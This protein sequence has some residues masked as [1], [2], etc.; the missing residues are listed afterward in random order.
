[1]FDED[2]PQGRS[3]EQLRGIEGGKVKAIYRCLATNAGL[4]WEGRSHETVLS[5]PLNRAIS[6]ANAALYGITEAVILTLG[7]SPS[8][9][10]VHRGD[11]RSFV[12]DVADCLKFKTVVPLAMRVAKESSEDIEGRIRRGCRDEFFSCGI[13]NQLVTIVNGVIEDGLAASD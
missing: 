4:K 2:A 8:I 12:F 7:Y 5:S 10:F 11:P 13:A 6:G 3:V 9:G 1:M